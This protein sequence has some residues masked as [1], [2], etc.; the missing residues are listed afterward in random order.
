MAHYI[1]I[2][3]F[4]FFSAFAINV[5]MVN[6]SPISAEDSIST[7]ESQDNI[8]TNVLFLD[9]IHHEE[10]IIYRRPVFVSKYLSLNGEYSPPYLKRLTKPPQT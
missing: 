4:T 1:L 2:F 8:K 5:T 3:F 9:E 10:F 6:F 7:Y